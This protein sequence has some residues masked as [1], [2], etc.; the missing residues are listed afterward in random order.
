[1]A[2]KSKLQTLLFARD[3]TQPEIAEAI[4]KGTSYVSH[5]VTGKKPWTTKDMEIIGKILEIPREEWLDYF[6]SGR[7][8]Q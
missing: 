2:K 4:D 8:E 3:I 6:I 5:R 1:M 7:A